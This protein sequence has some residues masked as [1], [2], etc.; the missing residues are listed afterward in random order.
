MR[1]VGETV[2]TA[3]ESEVEEVELYWVTRQLLRVAPYLM[4]MVGAATM[5][6][7]VYC[8]DTGTQPFRSERIVDLAYQKKRLWKDSIG[9]ITMGF[10]QFLVGSVWLYVRLGREPETESK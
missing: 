8:L 10:F 6:Y 7:G 2:G 1:Q 3:L 5:A 4:V 9:S